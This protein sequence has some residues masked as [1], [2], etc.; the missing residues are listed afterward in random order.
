MLI[1]LSPKHISVIA[2]AALLSGFATVGTYLQ[3]TEVPTSSTIMDNTTR[4]NDDDLVSEEILPSLLLPDH[5]NTVT[6]PL[7]VAMKLG[8]SP[9][10]QISRGMAMQ[11][12]NDVDRYW[13]YQEMTQFTIDKFQHRPRLI[14]GLPSTMTFFELQLFHGG[15]FLNEEQY[16]MYYRKS[17]NLIDLSVLSTHQQ[18]TLLTRIQKMDTPSVQDSFSF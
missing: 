4:F 15:S 12:L 10:T 1:S 17:D 6:V 16:R 13:L 2:A 3:F 11:R 7:Q 8:I 5:V 14:S 9:K 18:R